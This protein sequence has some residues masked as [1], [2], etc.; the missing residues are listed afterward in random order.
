[1]ANAWLIRYG[2]IA[3]K[4]LNRPY[5]EKL[6]VHNIKD[7]LAKSS[8]SYDSIIRVRGRIIILSSDDC[9]VLKHVFGIISLSPA[10][11]V[12]FEEVNKTA[13]ECY[14]SGTFRVS[15]QRLTKDT[16]ESSQDINI[17]VGSFIAENTKAK[18][19]LNNPD[20]DI[21]IEII[22]DHAYVFNKKIAAVGGLP[23]GCE[24]K[25]AVI[26]DDEDSVKAAYLMMKRGCKIVL[27]EK[28]KVNYNHLKSYEYGV[29]IELSKTVPDDVKFV[30][31]SESFN[32]L[33]PNKFKHPVIRPFL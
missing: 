4:G 20:V 2:E 14:T 19:N 16:A 21:G 3:L 1:M 25:V 15:A 22:A 8:K 18:V 9:S 13:L 23:L 27:I 26:L 32:N 11:Q 24:G 17:K 12:P 28:N 7:C 5:F 33:K 6:L 10:T 31:T 30:V 29:K